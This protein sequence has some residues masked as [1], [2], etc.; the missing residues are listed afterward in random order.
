MTYEENA[1]RLRTGA[2]LFIAGCI[3]GLA[4]GPAGTSMGFEA[5]KSYATRNLDQ[6]QAVRMQH[7]LD[8]RMES[9][10]AWWFKDSAPRIED[11]RFFMCQN[12]RRS[13]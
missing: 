5:G 6:E 10:L 4:F 7:F 8:H 11:A 2:A 3:V 1:W 9:C 13:D 12:K